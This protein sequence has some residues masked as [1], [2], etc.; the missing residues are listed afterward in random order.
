MINQ[1]IEL[2]LD[3]SE[4]KHI[5]MFVFIAPDYDPAEHWGD[6]WAVD[7]PEQIECVTCSGSGIGWHGSHM[8]PPEPCNWCEGSGLDPDGAPPDEPEEIDLDLQGVE[9]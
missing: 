8:E 2:V 3:I 1:P 6:D 4:I 7:T 9:L 5:D